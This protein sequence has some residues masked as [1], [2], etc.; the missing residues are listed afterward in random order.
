MN[1]NQQKDFIK[2]LERLVKSDE[3]M[4]ACGNKKGVHFMVDSKPELILAVLHAIGEKFPDIMLEYFDVSIRSYLA[5]H[6]AEHESVERKSTGR[7]DA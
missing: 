6:E 4:I 2:M 3:F 1:E 5:A 7:Y